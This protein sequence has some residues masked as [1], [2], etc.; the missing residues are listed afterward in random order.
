MAGRG[1]ISV[2]A[3]P[4]AS[5]EVRY[6]VN[7]YFSGSVRNFRINAPYLLHAGHKAHLR[8]SRIP[9]ALPKTLTSF[10]PNSSP[11]YTTHNQNHTA[12]RT[13]Q[14]CVTP[15]ELHL[16]YLPCLLSK[17]GQWLLLTSLI[18]RVTKLVSMLVFWL[19][20]QAVRLPL[21]PRVT[22]IK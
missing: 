20:P 19:L 6:D 10:S 14:Q 18:R 12:D 21:P 22:Q 1:W 11:T 4:S 16:S 13:S 17:P 15:E 3:F 2:F 5:L 7:N 8:K 9:R